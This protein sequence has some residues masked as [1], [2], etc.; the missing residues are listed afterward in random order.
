VTLDDGMDKQQ[1]MQSILSAVPIS[2]IE[3]KRPTLEDVF[4]EIVTGGGSGGDHEDVRAK[5]LAG[6]KETQEVAS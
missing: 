6:S 3:I 5:L 1:A 4:I 2:R